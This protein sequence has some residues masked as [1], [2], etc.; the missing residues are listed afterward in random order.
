MS[1]LQATRTIGTGDGW[2]VTE[3]GIYV[4]D[5]ADLDDLGDGRGTEVEEGE[6]VEQGCCEEGWRARVGARERVDEGLRRRGLPIA[7]VAQDGCEVGLV[8]P[9]WMFDALFI[10]GTTEWKLGHTAARLVAE[11][12]ARGKWTHM[13]RVNTL[14]RLRYAD[15]IGCDSVDGSSWARWRRTYLDD[16]LAALD[17]P[18]LAIPGALR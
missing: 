3:S 15:A 1:P 10:G 12:R 14:R 2:D 7:F 6:G 9:W 5:W 8:P 16:G 13:G 4:P 17:Q 18:Q 11:A